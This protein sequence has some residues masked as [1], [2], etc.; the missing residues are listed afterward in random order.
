MIGAALVIVA[1]CAAL[2]GSVAQ[3]LNLPY[4]AITA[5]VAAAGSALVALS[6]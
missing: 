2:V 4:L 5:L 3:R 1:L 6:L